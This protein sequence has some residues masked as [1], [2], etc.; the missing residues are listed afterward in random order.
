MDFQQSLTGTDEKS[1]AYKGAMKGEIPT[2][3]SQNSNSHV[4]LQLLLIQFV[5]IISA[6]DNHSLTGKKKGKA[7][8]QFS[9]MKAIVSKFC[10]SLEIN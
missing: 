9:G 5:D 2:T 7:V 4:A 10:L 1:W 6:L 3:V 8:E